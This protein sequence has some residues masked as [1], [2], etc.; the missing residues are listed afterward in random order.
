VACNSRLV[1]FITIETAACPASRGLVDDDATLGQALGRL[2]AG[3]SRS[4]LVRGGI[5]VQPSFGKS[6][7][8]ALPPAALSAN[9]T[10][11]AQDLERTLVQARRTAA[12]QIAG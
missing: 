2:A 7:L 3:S 6:R 5:L 8:P 11:L 9:L 4:R 10:M 1:G 12:L